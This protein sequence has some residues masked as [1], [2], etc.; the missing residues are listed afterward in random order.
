MFGVV[1]LHALTQGGYADAHRGL[2]NLL[3]PSVTGFVF[4]SGYFGI[5][6]RVKG[7]LKLLCIGLAVWLVLAMVNMKFTSSFGIGGFWWFLWMYLALMAIA[8]LAE[9]LFD[10]DGAGGAIAK[11]V[12]LVVVV[13]GWSYA[14]TKVP[15]LKDIIPLPTGLAPFSVLTFLAVYCV[16]RISRGYEAKIKTTW[17]VV[18]AFVSGVMCWSGLY[19]HNS[20]FC[21][22]FAGSMFYLFKRMPAL[23][24]NKVVARIALWLGPSM[25]SVYLLHTNSWGFAALR[26]AEDYLM[27]IGWNYYTMAFTV[28]IVIF[29]AGILLDMPR[30]LIGWMIGRVERG[31][32][33]R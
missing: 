20:P 5:K 13:Y 33:N 19:H 22:I 28:A 11:I 10:R 31:E 12:P 27:G 25:F 2:D 26:R 1:L 23:D 18:A 4:I 9:P 7:I 3:S 16:A 15:V 17:L 8:P 32:N 21:L 6:C 14:G 30:R 24:N 29:V